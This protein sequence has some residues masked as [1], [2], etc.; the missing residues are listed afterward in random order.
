MW[1]AVQQLHWIQNRSSFSHH[2]TIHT[3]FQE[4]TS[5][6]ATALS[7]AR[8]M[9]FIPKQHTIALLSYHSGN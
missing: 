5:M 2:S 7:A 4:S 9:F 6:I 8:M 3:F 1:S